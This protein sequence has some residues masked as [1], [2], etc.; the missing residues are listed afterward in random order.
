MN[1][2]VILLESTLQPGNDVASKEIDL[3]LSAIPVM[4]RNSFLADMN[5]MLAFTS[6]GPLKSFCYRRLMFL[7]SKYQLH[8]LLNEFRESAEQKKVPHRDFYNIRKARKELCVRPLS[9][10]LSAISGLMFLRSR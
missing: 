9:H 1:N 3:L 4:D 2:G 8:V 10:V 6:D 7:S 5:V